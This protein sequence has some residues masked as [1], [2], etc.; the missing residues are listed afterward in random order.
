VLQRFGLNLFLNESRLLR[1][2]HRL[3]LHILL[4]E[5]LHIHHLLLWGDSLAILELGHHMSLVLHVLLILIVEHLLGKS[6]LE[7]VIKLHPCSYGLL[8]VHVNLFVGGAVFHE[9]VLSFLILDSLGGLFD[10]DITSVRSEQSVGLAALFNFFI[11]NQKRRDYR[12]ALFLT[13]SRWVSIWMSVSAFSRNTISMPEGMR[14]SL[15]R[16]SCMLASYAKT[17][18]ECSKPIPSSIQRECVS[19]PDSCKY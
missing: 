17:K 3:R 14:Y 16:F 12:R 6:R 1:Y 18:D 7:S 8:H 2:K 13:S 15:N 10:W 5:G 11:L 9:Y 19:I 4:L